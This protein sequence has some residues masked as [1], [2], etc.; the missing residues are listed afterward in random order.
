MEVVGQ[1]LFFKSEI[2]NKKERKRNKDDSGGIFSALTKCNIPS[3]T[4]KH[5][6]NPTLHGNIT[7]NL[8]SKALHCDPGASGCRAPANRP[9]LTCNMPTISCLDL[10]HITFGKIYFLCIFYK[11][12]LF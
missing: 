11:I 12:F 3:H 5:A 7:F 6:K 8:K 1:L 4:K 9:L 10:L 2:K